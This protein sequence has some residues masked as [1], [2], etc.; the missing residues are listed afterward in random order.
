MVNSMGVFK[1]PNEHVPITVRN[2]AKLMGLTPGRIRQLI[3]A[4]KIEATK[5]RDGWRMTRAA[6]G[7][8]PL[9]PGPRDM[10]SYC[11]RCGTLQPSRKL[12]DSHC[13][14]PRATSRATAPKLG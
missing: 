4:G 11:T 6:L 7:L 2:A 9:R 1:S 12:A 13:R 10:P 8:P 5:T 3:I 14:V